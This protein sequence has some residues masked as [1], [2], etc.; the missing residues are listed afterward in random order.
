MLIQ[1]HDLVRRTDHQDNDLHVPTGDFMG[2]AEA[3]R[4]MFAQA[5]IAFR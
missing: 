5:P 1:V 2:P 4:S 3:K